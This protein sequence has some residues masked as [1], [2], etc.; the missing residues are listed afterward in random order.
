MRIDW[1]YKPTNSSMPYELDERS[2][3]RESCSMT[4]SGPLVTSRVIIPTLQRDQLG[5]YWCETLSTD[6]GRE[7]TLSSSPISS[8]I[9]LVTEPC[10]QPVPACPSD[11]VL[12]EGTVT[13]KCASGI[14]PTNSFPPI[15]SPIEVY[16]PWTTAVN[17]HTSF[18]PLK[19][20]IIAVNASVHANT[21]INSNNSVTLDVS[22]SIIRAL[23]YIQAGLALLIVLVIIIGLH[24]CKY[25]RQIRKKRKG[26]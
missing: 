11:V 26:E 18:L 12:Y 24:I 10:Q 14:E 21:N 25:L 3:I 13:S 9:G 1:M 4:P 6:G 7:N 15:C 16:T 8:K 2:V 22:D 23:I 17:S 19:T 5:Y 20:T